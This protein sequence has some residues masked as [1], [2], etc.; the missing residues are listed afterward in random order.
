MKTLRYAPVAIVL[1]SAAAQAQE[2]PGSLDINCNTLERPSQTQVARALGIDNFTSAYAARER[3][4][5]IA[6][7]Q[8]LRGVA[9]ARIVADRHDPAIATAEVAVA[10][11]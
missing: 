11:R 8:C 9:Q 1:A 7:S 3:V 4:M 10:K 6:R 5:Q 2:N